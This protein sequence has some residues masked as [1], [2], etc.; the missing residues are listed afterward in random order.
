MICKWTNLTSQC[1]LEND[2][3][4]QQISQI[5][6]EKFWVVGLVFQVC[7]FYTSWSCD[8]GLQPIKLHYLRNV[9]STHFSFNVY[10]SANRAKNVLSTQFLFSESR[11]DHFFFFPCQ[12]CC[13]LCSFLGGHCDVRVIHSHTI[14]LFSVF[15]KF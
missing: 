6:Y 11:M 5:R 8:K 3:K 7:L 10:F 2:H 15:F 12:I 14:I 13:L 1:L 4:R 9:W